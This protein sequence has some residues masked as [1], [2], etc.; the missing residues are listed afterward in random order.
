[1]IVIQELL[2]A[3][4]DPQ[5]RLRVP[6]PQAPYSVVTAGVVP[7]EDDAR[8]S[9]H[10]RLL[11]LAWAAVTRTPGTGTA[12]TRTPGTRSERVH[13]VLGC[14][15]ILV[16]PGEDREEARL[17]FSLERAGEL[18]EAHP[19]GSLGLVEGPLPRLEASSE[20]LVNAAREALGRARASG[21]TLLGFVRQPV[22]S[23]LEAWLAPGE[24]TP[25]FRSSTLSHCLVHG[26][27]A[28]FR[29]ETHEID[30]DPDDRA[31][32]LALAHLMDET[33]GGAPF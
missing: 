33:E 20:H 29:L 6:S 22:P 24:R 18:L 11:R 9:P 16:G 23:M 19:P 10:A 27:S 5:E 21:S 2:P 1:M 12:L 14:E 26:G 31:V 15:S 4:S 3:L 32:A 7:R 28:V 17:R 30:P 8:W 25:W 13:T